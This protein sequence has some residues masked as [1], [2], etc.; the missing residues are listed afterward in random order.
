MHSDGDGDVFEE[1]G[2]T[3]E[4]LATLL[5][6]YDRGDLDNIDDIEGIAHATDFIFKLWCDSSYDLMRLHER[7]VAFFGDR[8]QILE[9]FRH[10]SGI[11]IALDRRL[12]TVHEETPD[13]ARFKVI[14]EKLVAI[15]AN[16]SY[17][18]DSIVQSYRQ[19]YC[20]RPDMFQSLPPMKMDVFFSPMVQDDM[21]NH[22]KLIRWYLE[23]CNR[24]GYRRQDT[25]LFAP[26]FTEDGKF[27][28][29]YVFACEVSFFVY[30]AIH[31]YKQHLWQF[32][33]LTE[34]P[35]IV[36]MCIDYLEKCCDDNLPV[37]AKDR[38]KFS[39]RN[40]LYDARA[41]SFYPYDGE[42]PNWP[43]KTVCANYIDV[44]FESEVFD[45]CKDP[46]DIPTP[47]IQRILD[48]QEFDSTVC[49]WLFASIGRMIFGV[50]DLDNW[51]YFPFCKGTA[52]SGKSTLLRLAAKFYNDVDVG[53]LMSEGQKTFSIEHIYNKYVFF[54][55]DVD[56]KMNF[57]LT[58][59]N[60]MVSGE[61]IAIERKFK[62]PIQQL[63]TT[64]GAFAG[65]SYPP[66]VD[67]AG[68]VSRRMLIFLFSKVVRTVD[69]N[70]FDK[71]MLEMGSFM[72]KCVACYHDM[73]GSFGGRGIWDRG[74]LPEYF[75]NTKRQMQAETN[76]LQAFLQSEHCTVGAGEHSD[77]NNFRVVYISFCDTMRLPKKKLTLDFCVPLF[78][79]LDI[80]IVDVPSGAS[81][82]DHGGYIGKY[83][84]GV[85]VSE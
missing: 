44:V 43:P 15:S 73:V 77:F 50:G 18:Y 52:G 13:E 6:E 36:R 84:T 16:I 12:N 61:S 27:T 70:L 45:E 59:W 82:A 48:S 38:S 34:K 7:N 39:F 53:N 37:L 28:R 19:L 17:G 25:S 4:D 54:C 23:Q 67:Q 64:G 81:P 41:D 66:W 75:H 60:Q 10:Y 74:V 5:L 42:P 71:C 35:S 58:R 29:T 24:R 14:S 65:N 63:W 83:I 80:S 3:F 11:V 9:R 69:T 22:Q 68:N 51:Q 78:D 31:P 47:N 32:F 2:D 8:G 40:G 1:V 30:D 79:P 76:P 56:D 33:A 49:R 21:K 72:K 62:I 85:S 20:N 26:K 55:Y 46:L 57:S